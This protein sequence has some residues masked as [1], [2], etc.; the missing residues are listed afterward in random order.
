MSTNEKLA[1]MVSHTIAATIENCVSRELLR[2]DER[3]IRSGKKDLAQVDR[4][5]IAEYPQ[6]CILD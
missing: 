6:S 4:G 5:T 1:R 2:S 3:A